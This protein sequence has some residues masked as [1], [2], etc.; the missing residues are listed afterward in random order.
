MML[1]QAHGL[2]SPTAFKSSRSLEDRSTHTSRSSAVDSQVSVLN[3]CVSS[4]Q[5]EDS[6]TNNKAS[7]ERRVAWLEE[8]VAVMQH[9]LRDVYT[10]GVGGGMTRGADGDA[11]LRELVARLDGDLEDEKQTRKAL[12]ERVDTAEGQLQTF[13]TELERTMSDIIRRIDRS[14][15]ATATSV[16]VS[17]P[18]THTEA[19]IRTLIQRV[20]QGLLAGVSALQETLPSPLGPMEGANG[21]QFSLSRAESPSS[22]G[23]QVRFGAP[24]QQTT[25]GQLAALG[26]AQLAHPGRSPSQTIMAQCALGGGSMTD[27]ARSPRGALMA[28]S[29]AAGAKM[30]GGSLSLQQEGMMPQASMRARSPQAGGPRGSRR[31]NG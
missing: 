6:A 24:H 2:A 15:S 17:D 14:M 26:Q 29:A 18:Q 23:R 31:V 19:K 30:A 1:S 7:V 28:Q 20:D 8:E 21:E 13:A 22:R 27:P 5:S 9:R 4:G 25:A 12:E 10:S 11:R 3:A 16:A